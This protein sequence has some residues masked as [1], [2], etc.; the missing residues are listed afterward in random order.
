MTDETLIADLVRAG[1]DAALVGRVSNAILSA[2]VHGQSSDTLD[3]RRKLDRERKRKERE[4]ARLSKLTSEANDADVSPKLSSDVSTDSAEKR[5]DLS[6]LLSLENGLSTKQEKKAQKEKK[7]PVERGKRGTRMLAGA[8]I[9]DVD[10]QF[11][12]AHGHSA[13]TIL[14]MWAEFVDFWI[15]VPGQRGCKLDW[16]ATWRNRV[17]NLSA[18]RG[19]RASPNGAPRPGSREDRQEKTYNAYQKLRQ[20]AHPQADEPGSGD[21]PRDPSF[22]LLPFAKPA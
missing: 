14:T 2:S 5:C 17:R 16:P 15:G 1:L 13:E 10:R 11:A 3:T 19:A 12:R 9:S 18:G 20:H 6:S 7:E 22:G 21:A 8:V 4:L